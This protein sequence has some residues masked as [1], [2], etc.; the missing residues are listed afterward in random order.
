MMQRLGIKPKV[1]LLSHSNFGDR[2]DLESSQKM[3]AA[4]EIIR[5][6]NP[7]LEIEGEMQADAALAEEVRKAVY[8]SNR[9]S[10]SANLL[11][12]PNIDA[13]NIGYNLMKVLTDGNAV[14]PILVGL[15]RPAMVLTKVATSR[16]I[17]NVAAIAVTETQAYY[18]RLGISKPV[19]K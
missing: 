12:M 9:L 2:G 5:A 16:R 1:A 4:L 6:A 15:E 3:R 10:G 11:V 7:E 13:A 14:G 8:P 17:L 18:E 19:V